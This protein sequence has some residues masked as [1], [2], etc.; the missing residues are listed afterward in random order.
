MKKLW[1]ILFTIISVSNLYSQGITEREAISYVQRVE[2][3]QLGKIS[4]RNSYQAQTISPNNVANLYVVQKDEGGW[5]LISSDNRVRAIL[6][7]SDTGVFDYNDM[8]EGMFWLFSQYE[9][10]IAALQTDDLIEEHESWK[11]FS[12]EKDATYSLN[13]IQSAGPTAI[14]L[15]RLDSVSWNQSYNN[16]IECAPSYNMKCPTF[17]AADCSHNYVGCTAVAMAQ[18]MWYWQWPHYAVVPDSVYSNGN[19]FA[20]S[21]VQKIDWTIIPKELKSNTPLNQ[22]QMLAT[23][24]RDCG[25]CSHPRYAS[26]GTGISLENAANAMKQ[27]F[28]YSSNIRYRSRG[29]IDG[30][31]VNRLKAEID[32]GR[33]ILYAGYKS[34]GGGHSFVI[35]GYNTSDYF[36]VNWGYGA[37]PKTWISLDAAV[38]N[39]D[40]YNEDQEALF[41]IYPNYQCGELRQTTTPTTN[42]IYE[43]GDDIVLSNAILANTNVA[44]C[45]NS[46][47]RLTAGFHASIGSNAMFSINHIPCANTRNNIQLE[48]FHKKENLQQDKV[49]STGCPNVEVLYSPTKDFV[50]IKGCISEHPIVEIYNIQGLRIS[51][52]YDAKIEISALPQGIYCIICTDGFRK[53]SLKISK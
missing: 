51:V 16:D 12:G 46:E 49:E 11:L 42:T 30:V 9:K 4:K 48:P 39:T 31:W 35:Y 27:N 2:N 6:A 17:Q 32:A 37:T 25:Y 43:R 21:H 29:L 23:L 34:T 24:L 38:V 53:Y 8:P 36:K 5:F 50:L 20:T 7:Y 26:T 19:A 45:S 52:Q 44:Y 28:G 14:V 22:S 41:E 18:I 33:P 40:A 10:Q 1:V 13:T 15:S 47:I 3:S